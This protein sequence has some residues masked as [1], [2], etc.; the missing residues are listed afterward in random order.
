MILSSVI[1]T[2][3]LIEKQD[4]GLLKLLVVYKAY[5]IEYRLEE[6]MMFPVCDIKRRIEDLDPGVRTG[7]SLEF[8]VVIGER[9]DAT[10]GIALDGHL[11]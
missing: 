11:K 8:V 7:Q 3:Y 10:G 9:P 6:T 5:E 2:T 4:R 1:L